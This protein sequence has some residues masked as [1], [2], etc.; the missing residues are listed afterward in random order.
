M[1]SSCVAD[2]ASPVDSSRTSVHLTKTVWPFAKGDGLVFGRRTKSSL[3][4]HSPG[5]LSSIATS[6]MVAVPELS[7]KVTSRPST[8]AITRTSPPRCSKRRMLMRPV[9][10]TWPDPKLVTRPIER[11]T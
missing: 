2:W 7:T 3:T 10:M 9:V 4:A 1:A 6:S 11:K 8:S 5:P